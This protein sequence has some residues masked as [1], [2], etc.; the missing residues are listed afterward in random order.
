VILTRAQITDLV[1]TYGCPEYAVTTAVA[2]A[3]AESGGD[4]R[5]T[6]AAGNTPPSTD[7]GLWQ[8]NS[9]WHPEVSDDCAFD[10]W[11]ATSHAAE[12]SRY[13]TDFSPWSAYNNGSYRTYL[14]A[15]PPMNVPYVT[16][17]EPDG[18]G[19]A[20]CGPACLT[21][22]LAYD[23][24]I[25][26]DRASMHSVADYMRD[27]YYDGDWW[28]GTY[29]DFGMMRWLVEDV[30]GVTLREQPSWAA[31]DVALDEGRPVILL[32]D[33][34]VLQPR[35]Y[36][37]TAAFN[38][39]H[40]IVLTGRDVARGVYAVNDPLAVYAPGPGAYTAD[41][42]HRATALVGGVYAVT[43][44]KKEPPVRPEDQAIVDAVR[45]L[46]GNADSVAGWI[47]QIGALEG[48]N[49]AKQGQLEQLNGVNTELQSQVDA[50]RAEV[51]ALRNAPPPAP[52][53]VAWV[54]V[55]L[56]DGREVTR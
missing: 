1:R 30:Y 47:N 36:Q 50:L 12:I 14:E 44:A 39:H 49:A 54:V 7:R 53:E 15:T 37:A 41:S 27:R 19:Y 51:D 21:M 45:A 32:L 16:Q 4:S 38:A 17:V 5:A 31:I 29:T 40:F 25:G 56:T 34:S 11:C 20:N 43:L 18:S 22:L 10:P 9:Y 55:K 24:H 2:V 42:L 3:L 23:G 52:A 35:Q 33:N 28:L 46:G 26:A 48:D 8:I 13:W 6:N